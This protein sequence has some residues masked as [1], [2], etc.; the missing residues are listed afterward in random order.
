MNTLT[1]VNEAIKILPFKREYAIKM[2]QES[3]FPNLYLQGSWDEVKNQDIWKQNLAN[4]YYKSTF[5]N[6][7]MYIHSKKGVGKSTLA[8]LIAIWFRR[9]FTYNIAFIN[10]QILASLIFHNKKDEI[11]SYYN[12]NVLIFDNFGKHHDS[13]YF[14]TEL[15]NLIEHRYM[16][17]LITI[18]TSN[19]SIKEL[20]EMKGYEDIAD[21]FQDKSIYDIIPLQGQNKRH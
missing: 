12:H 3:G 13:K 5:T 10:S 2:L 6:K 21:R 15:Y 14:Q 8:G 18:V 19:L 4:D 20:N 9:N 17:K 16:H 11:L 7:S 1:E